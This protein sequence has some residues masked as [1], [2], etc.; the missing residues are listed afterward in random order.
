MTITELTAVYAANISAEKAEGETAHTELHNEF[1][2]ACRRQWP[3]MPRTQKEVYWLD[4]LKGG[5]ARLTEA[6]RNLRGF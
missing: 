4:A 3:L 1:I 5:V 6:E 2:A